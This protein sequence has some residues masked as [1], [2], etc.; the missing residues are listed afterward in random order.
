MVSDDI[1]EEV[2]EERCP[3]EVNR[4]RKSQQPRETSCHHFVAYAASVSSELNESIDLVRA[5]AL[6]TKGAFDFS[7]C[8]LTANVGL[9]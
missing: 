3:C 1:E 6:L 8:A 4:D 5:S 2:I 7:A 9:Y